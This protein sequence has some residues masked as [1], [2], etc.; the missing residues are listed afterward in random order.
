LNTDENT[1]GKVWSSQREF[2]ERKNWTP[3]KKAHGKG[4]G[5]EKVNIEEKSSRERKRKGKIEN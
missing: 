1:Q 3:K 2:R 5:K 4:K